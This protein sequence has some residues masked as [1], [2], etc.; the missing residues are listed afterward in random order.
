MLDPIVKIKNL[1]GRQ[2]GNADL[3]KPVVVFI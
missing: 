2:K 3:N 1:V